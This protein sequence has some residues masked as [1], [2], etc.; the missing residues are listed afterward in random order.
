MDS[1]IPVIGQ[2]S[3]L[4]RIQNEGAVPKTLLAYMRDPSAHTLFFKLLAKKKRKNSSLATDRRARSYIV[5]LLGILLGATS[6]DAP[7]AFRVDF[8]GQPRLNDMYITCGHGYVEEGKGLLVAGLKRVSRN[9]GGDEERRE[10]Y[11]SYS[12]FHSM[13]PRTDPGNWLELT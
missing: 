11:N 5:T 1:W 4:G 8:R 13:I 6:A 3:S 10:G 12:M 2:S 9:A 7:D